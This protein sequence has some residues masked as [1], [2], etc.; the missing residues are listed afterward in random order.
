MLRRL[1]NIAS[2][3][4]LVACVVLMGMWVRSYWWIEGFVFNPLGASSVEGVSATGR[5]AIGI[6]SDPGQKQSMF[7]LTRRPVPI[8]PAHLL[9]EA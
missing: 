4:C 7:R 3:V 1:L 9:H 5:I 2:I 8:C 6:L